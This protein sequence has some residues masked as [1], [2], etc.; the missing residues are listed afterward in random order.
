MDIKDI[1]E[2]TDD[3]MLICTEPDEIVYLDKEDKEKVLDGL[4]ELSERAVE[5]FNYTYKY[6]MELETPTQSTDQLAKKEFFATSSLLLRTLKDIQ[7]IIKRADIEE[8]LKKAET[9]V[10]MRL[11]GRKLQTD[12]GTEVLDVRI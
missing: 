8:V 6:L 3:E 5:L 1:I 11:Y 10:E 9:E 2:I 4:P 12:I 7:S